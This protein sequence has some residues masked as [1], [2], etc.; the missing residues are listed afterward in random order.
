MGSPFGRDRIDFMNCSCYRDLLKCE[1]T[2]IIEMPKPVFEWGNTTLQIARKRNGTEEIVGELPMEYV[3]G[4][5]FVF[6]SLT[7]LIFLIYLIARI[8][9]NYRRT[10][11]LSEAFVEQ[12]KLGI[13]E[14][15]PDVGRW[16]EE[17]LVD[18]TN[19]S[20]F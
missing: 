8:I 14:S 1:E 9:L 13:F 16:D 5:F 17:V 15:R 6:L 3:L 19:A 11:S 7:M 18:R 12:A 10:Q 4:S 2:S 20:T